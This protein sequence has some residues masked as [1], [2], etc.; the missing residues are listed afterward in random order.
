MYCWQSVDPTYFQPDDYCP[1]IPIFQSKELDEIP[2]RDVRGNCAV[3]RLWYVNVRLANPYLERKELIELAVAKLKN[4]GN[5]YKF[6]K[7][8][9]KYIAGSM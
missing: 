6:I 9:Q 5:L 3:W 4:M 2:G 1:L 8:Y 7:S